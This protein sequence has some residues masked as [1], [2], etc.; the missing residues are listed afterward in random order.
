MNEVYIEPTTGTPFLITAVLFDSLIPFLTKE[1]ML[2]VSEGTQDGNNC[3]LGYNSDLKRSVN[4]HA[5]Y[6]GEDIVA[7]AMVLKND[8]KHLVRLYTTPG[9]RRLGLA[10][11][12]LF[13]LD[14]QSLGCLRENRA[15]LA[16]YK[17]LGFEPVDESSVVMTL[18]RTK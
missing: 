9:F 14:I 1:C 12:F 17:R 5:A 11:V 3:Y 10:R 2:H 8:P 13:G 16:L 18:K 4:C 15:A 7:Y 6:Y